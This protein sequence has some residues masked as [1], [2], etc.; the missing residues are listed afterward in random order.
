MQDIT[1]T[2]LKQ[3]RDAGED[4]FLIDVREADEYAVSDIGGVFMP[5]SDFQSFLPS[6]EDKKSEEIVVQCRSGARSG[7]VCE[8]LRNQGF[9]NVRN[10]IGGIKEYAAT[11][12]PEMPVA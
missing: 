1:V 3:R 9:E 11:F 5:L 2:E 10:L 6:L 7:R 4:I 12:D 8:F